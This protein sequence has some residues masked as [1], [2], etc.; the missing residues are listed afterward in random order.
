MQLQILLGKEP[1]AEIQLSSLPQL[2]LGSALLFG[3]KE[4]DQQVGCPVKLNATEGPA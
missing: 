3:Y 2:L 4:L 1:P